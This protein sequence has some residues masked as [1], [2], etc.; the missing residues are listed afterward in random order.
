MTSVLEPLFISSDEMNPN[1][2]WV[3]EGKGEAT[4]WWRTAVLRFEDGSP[5]IEGDITEQ[6]QQT[7]LAEAKSEGI[8]DGYYFVCGPDIMGNIYC[9]KDITFIALGEVK[10]PFR[11]VRNARNM[12]E[13]LTTQGY[14]GIV[15][16]NR[17]LAEHNAC[18]VT[19]DMLRNRR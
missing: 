18:Y 17:E 2:S 19:L 5:I 10:L 13:F 9:F 12:T 11:K 7:I 14:K 4:V 6:Q 8:S 15:F 16:I 1:F 3:P